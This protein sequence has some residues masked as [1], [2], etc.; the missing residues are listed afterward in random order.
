MIRRV[1]FAA[2]LVTVLGAGI[3]V[4]RGQMAPQVSKMTPAE[5]GKVLT[6]TD[7][8]IFNKLIKD[9]LAQPPSPQLTA[10]FGQPNLTVANYA[11][12]VFV[13]S[14]TGC[15]ATLVGPHVLITAAHCTPGRTV[16]FPQGEE[17]VAAICHKLRELEPQSEQHEDDLALCFSAKT[18]SSTPETLSFDPQLVAK[19]QELVLSGYGLTGVNPTGTSGKKDQVGKFFNLGIVTVFRSDLNATLAEVE[20]RGSQVQAGDSGGG[21]FAVPTGT[22]RRFLVAVSKEMSHG[23]TKASFLTPLAAPHIAALITRWKTG[24]AKAQGIAIDICGLDG[25]STG[26]Q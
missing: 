20:T 12:S 15:T 11:S 19:G 22:T 2:V 5:L 16:V 9:P 21:V 24:V 18:L 1:G 3:I 13:S 26:C 6:L 10:R 14:L 25:F 23:E 7:V 17:L 8:S 4:V